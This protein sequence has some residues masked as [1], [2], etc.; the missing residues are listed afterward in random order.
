VTA[1]ATARAGGRQAGSAPPPRRTGGAATDRLEA[2][3]PPPRTR[4]RRLEITIAAAILL[5]AIGVGAILLLGGGDD[6]E[7]SPSSTTPAANSAPVVNTVE[8]VN[9]VSN[10][11]AEQ[12]TDAPDETNA[13]VTTAP[14]I[15]RCTAE[16]GRCVF[17]DNISRENDA[18]VVRYTTSGYEPELDA[19]P[20]SH[21]VHFY[22]NTVPVD[23]AGI[24][25]PPNWVA[26][27]TDE[28]GELIYRFPVASVPGG[29]T[30]LC[31]S[32]ANVNHGLDD[33]LQDC[34]PLP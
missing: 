30:Q 5:V 27:D 14:S 4:G 10:T 16:T 1:P 13:V 8:Q 18:F 22:F 23:Q 20:Q 34:V 15:H 21:H 11:E 3:G 17:I 12:A 33:H 32:V 19:G 2:L 9:S 31:A 29:A 6:P 25:A 24:P 28:N 7:T 26:Y